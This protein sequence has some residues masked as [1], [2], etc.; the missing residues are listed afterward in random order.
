MDDS[1]SLVDNEALRNLYFSQATD[2][3]KAIVKNLD[4]QCSIA[5]IASLY[6]DDANLRRTALM[7]VYLLWEMDAVTL[8]AAQEPTP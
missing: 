4:G 7:A 8:E 3:E 5:E 6:G 1:E 2:A